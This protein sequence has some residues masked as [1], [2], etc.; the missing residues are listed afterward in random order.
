VRGVERLGRVWVIA[1]VLLALAGPAR[2][3]HPGGGSQVAPSGGRYDAG[4]VAFGAPGRGPWLS[5]GGEWRFARAGRLLSGGTAV[6]GEGGPRVD[7][8]AAR[9]HLAL[10]M[11]RGTTVELAVPWLAVAAV[12]SDGGRERWNGVG[13]VSVG[14][15][16]DLGRFYSRAP[17]WVPRV[18]VRVGLELP[19]GRVDDRTVATVRR[20]VTDGAELHYATYVVE[21][22]L[23]QGAVAVTADL[24]AA[25]GIGARGEVAVAVRGRVPVA[26][27]RGE[28]RRGAAVAAELVWAARLWAERVVPFAGLGFR[29]VAGDEVGGGGAAGE[30]AVAASQRALLVLAGARVGLGRGVAASVAA[31]FPVVSRVEGVQLVESWGLSVGLSATFGLR[32]VAAKP[33]SVQV[34]VS[35]GRGTR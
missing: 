30:E 5:V 22:G 31:E 13:D 2:G 33:R 4:R 26:D 16:Q 15:R 23:G 35:S 20:F 25:W 8:Q 19:T 1:A 12:R 14:V 9:L 11:V 24:D 21:A 29:Y 34:P 6:R 17:G 28:A 32:R 10:A 27:V 3:H 18:A 7:A